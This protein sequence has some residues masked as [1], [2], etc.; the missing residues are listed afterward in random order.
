M[1]RIQ[2]SL[3]LPYQVPT[4]T[5][6]LSERYV[7]TH[8]YIIYFSVHVVLLGIGSISYA[9]PFSW[10]KSSIMPVHAATAGN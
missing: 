2:E 6:I 4:Y 3:G 9:C 10:I 7:L 8:A 1:E 5:H